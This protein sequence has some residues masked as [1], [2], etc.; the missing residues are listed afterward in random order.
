MTTFCSESIWITIEKVKSNRP[1]HNLPLPMG[2]Q[3]TFTLKRQVSCWENRQNPVFQPFRTHSKY[4]LS[5]MVSCIF[6]MRVTRAVN[7]SIFHHNCCMFSTHHHHSALHVIFRG[8]GYYP[9][10]CMLKTD[11]TRRAFFNNDGVNKCA[12][13]YFSKRNSRPSGC[14]T[15][16]GR[17][18]GCS[19]DG[20]FR[21]IRFDD[22]LQNVACWR[23]IYILINSIPKKD[24]TRQ[25]IVARDL[26]TREREVPWLQRLFLPNT[27][28]GLSKW[29]L[30]LNVQFRLIKTASIIANQNYILDPRT[31]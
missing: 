14:I 21:H 23:R 28:F 15:R 5:R 17:L 13:D 3:Q 2:A 22:H 9:E 4:C 12:L 31:N 16:G 29:Y 7:K 10:D 20:N 1:S 30:S 18:N 8:T 19:W 6:I 26:V 25:T 27:R 24:W 11:V